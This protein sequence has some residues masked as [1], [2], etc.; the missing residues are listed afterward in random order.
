MNIKTIMKG[1]PK[2]ITRISTT[3]LLAGVLAHYF[4]QFKIMVHGGYFF[5][6]EI[7]NTQEIYLSAIAITSVLTILIDKYVVIFYDWLEN[8]LFTLSKHGE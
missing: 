6:N 8:K 7:F 2:Q 3:L 5:E 4:V 1:I